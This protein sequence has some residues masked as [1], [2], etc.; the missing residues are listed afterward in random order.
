MELVRIVRLAYHD[1]EEQGL[2][3]DIVDHRKIDAREKYEI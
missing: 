2:I 3:F 1:T